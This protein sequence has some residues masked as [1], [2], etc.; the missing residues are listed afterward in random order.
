MYAIR[1]RFFTRPTACPWMET[2]ETKG[3]VL[4]LQAPTPFYITPLNICTS[5]TNT[6]GVSAGQIIPQS[7]LCSCRGR[8]SLPSRPMGEL[9]LR[10]C[11]SVEA[12]VSRLST[13]ETP[14]LVW[15]ALRWS[16]QFPVAREYLR[17][18]VMVLVLMASSRLKSYTC[19]TIH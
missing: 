16:P 12:K 3:N 7:V 15:W 5:I 10:R 6:S 17:P 19:A 18:S 13:W 9:S 14:A 8:A 1:A 4:Q 2:H 11:D